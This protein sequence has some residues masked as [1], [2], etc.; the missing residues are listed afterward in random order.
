MKRLAERLNIDLGY[1]LKGGSALLVDYFMVAAIQLSVTICFTNF[2]PK[3]IYGLYGWVQASCMLLVIATL[4][5]FPAAMVRSVARGFEG[6]YARGQKLRTLAGLAG[7]GALVAAGVGFWA[8]GYADKGTGLLLAS[9]VFPLVFSLADAKS[10]LEGKQRFGWMAVAHAGTIALASA[11]TIAAILLSGEFLVILAANLGSRSI[12]NLTVTWI[13]IRRSGNRE[14]DAEF[15]RFGRTLTLAQIPG[16]LG[17]NFDRVY[18]GSVVEMAVMANYHL[19]FTVAEPFHILGTLV[20]KLAYP[21]LVQ[22]SGAAIAVKVR[23]RLW[24][25]IPGL[26]LMGGAYG[27]LMNLLVPLLFPKYTDALPYINLMV[28]AG[29]VAVLTIYLETFFLSQESLHRW[30]YTVSVGRP[31]LMIAL[32]PPLVMW[33]GAMGAI[34]AK[35][36]VR[37][38][39]SVVLGIKLFAIA[40]PKEGEQG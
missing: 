20:N 7:S 33:Q 12:A 18:V 13:C 6:D 22:R 31:I 15:G 4:P 1:W 17:Y 27:V 2:V 29:V 23:R 38:L 34:W 14:R 26:A 40:G 25:V 24:L 37:A 35:L 28:A 8:A 36:S 16:V 5:G 21:R 11:S 32:T 10:W 39:S 30:Y 9:V 19:A 3:E